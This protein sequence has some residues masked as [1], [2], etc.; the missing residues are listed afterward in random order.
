MKLQTLIQTVV[1][2]GSLLLFTAC[3]APSLYPLYTEEDQA[4]DP[5]LVGTWVDDDGVV[6]TLQA[7][8]RSG[9]SLTVVEDGESAE[10]S[11]HLVQLSAHRFLDIYPD[12]DLP[13]DHGFLKPHLVPA[14]TFWRLSLEGDTMRLVGL[15]MEW[16]EHELKNGAVSVTHSLW[17]DGNDLILLT[18]QTSELQEFLVAQAENA[19]A[20]SQDRSG[21]TVVE[22]HRVG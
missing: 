5:E 3:V 18:A 1:V 8:S 22:L 20:F 2:T 7:E 21:D 17:G 19:E 16:L 6:Y 14:H 12:G 11:A 10:F 15:N 4:F 13:I 9:Y